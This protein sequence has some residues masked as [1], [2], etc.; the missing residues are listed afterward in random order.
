MFSSYDAIH[1]RITDRGVIE[2][3][4]LQVLE[5]V[6]ICQRFVIYLRIDRDFSLL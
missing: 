4:A 5:P 2:R 3:E 6:Q 1:S